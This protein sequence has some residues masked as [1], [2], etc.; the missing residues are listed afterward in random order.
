M[1]KEYDVVVVGAGPAGLF[2]AYG[3]S[4][5]GLSVL[6]VDKGRDIKKRKPEEVMCGVGGA[7]AFSDGTLNLRPDVGGNLDDYTK[8]NQKSWELVNE[9]GR[10][11]TKFGAP[12]KTYGMD[13][14]A[15]E[16]LEKKAASVGITFIRIRQQRMGSENTPK[17]VAALDSYLKKKGV[18]FLT[19]TVVE[20]ILVEDGACRG[21]ILEG[22]RKIKSKTVVLSPGR[23]G[24]DWA[25]KLIK[26]HGISF[27]YGPIDVGVRVEVPSL[28]ME[29]VISV[30]QDP[31][32]HIRT[33]TYDDFVRT[34]CTNHEGFVVKESYDSFIG[35]NGYS[36]LDKKTENTNFAFLV[37]VHLTQPVEDTIQ[38]GES[39]AHLA[40]TIGGGKPILQRLGDLKRGRRS[41]PEDILGNPIKP[42]LKDVTPGDI[43]MALPHRVVVDI[44]DGLD[45]LDH[46]IPGVVADSTLLYTPEIKYYALQVSVD[47]N[48]MTSLPNLY[49]AGDGV[50]L[51]R[52]L[53][54]ASATGLLAA[55]GILTTLK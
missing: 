9:V 14:A 15:V 23:V 39:I 48:M 47:G 22:G 45:A 43:S 27:D 49:A 33:K 26:K 52:D 46:V 40:T 13:S 10:I 7:G 2:C 12:K 3:L 1:R 31:K 50:G 51:S 29:D 41:H 28:V 44:L 34:F 25:E 4:G 5:R 11:F 8:D 35:V 21:V 42:T 6:V 38:Y 36:R 17:V 18:S 32:F 19:E 24:A 20:D 16:K 37:R 55:Q 54:N 30:N 53:V